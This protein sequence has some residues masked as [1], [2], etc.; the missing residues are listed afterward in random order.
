MPV[1]FEW[2]EV[3]F[4]E[5]HR[6]RWER[7]ETLMREQQLDH[8]LL[9]GADHI[10]YVTDFRAQLTNEPD[11]FVAVVSSDGTADLMVPY[12]DEAVAADAPS[13][14]WIKRLLPLPSWSP[15][16][17]NPV[18]W[19]RAVASALGGGA[20]RI[21]VD[22]IDTALLGG[23][24]EAVPNAEIHSVSGP[25]FQLR[26]AKLDLEIVLLEAA[27]R[28]N[29][30]AMEAATL[31]A[32]PGA[33][34]HDVLAAAMAHQQAA[35]VE[36][37]THSVCNLR[38]GSGDWFAAGREFV[39]G[40][41]FF[42]DIGCYGVGGY[43]SDAARTGFVGEPRK[44]HADA[45][46]TLLESH[47]LIQAAAQP[48]VRASELQRITNDFLT[49]KGYFGTPY[50]VGHGVG[51]RICELPSIYTTEHMDE[52]AVLVEGEVIAIEPELS[53]ERDGMTTV[54]KIEDNFVVTANGL[55]KLTVAPT[56]ASASR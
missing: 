18:T 48:G 42:F 5:L 30:A 26:R 21:G 6:Q 11:W 36:F 8:L 2:P 34:D 40:D 37:V 14:P 55:R 52:D 28:V 9:T 53:Y 38:N 29:T 33:T 39:D 16:A 50:A 22:G 47:E 15:P 1:T 56:A 25:L 44:H 7:V 32:V 17:A 23:L 20:R 41:P 54:L 46:A 12:V 19:V 27:S 51:L 31:V 13:K 45:Y 49:G 43:A 3:D 35:G 24:R 4:A 10:R